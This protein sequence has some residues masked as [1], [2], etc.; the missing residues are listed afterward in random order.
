[1]CAC[2]HGQEQEAKVLARGIIYQGAGN[3]G[4]GDGR[5]FF[6]QASG[7]RLLEGPQLAS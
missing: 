4:L 2:M 3:E 7:N 6:S 1:M 5:Y